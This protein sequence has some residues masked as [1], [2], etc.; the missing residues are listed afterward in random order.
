MGSDLAKIWIHG[1]SWLTIEV[2]LRN[3]VVLDYAASC[4]TT[5]ASKGGSQRH[6]ADLKLFSV[7]LWFTMISLK[8][9][10]QH[11]LSRCLQVHK[12]KTKFGSHFLSSLYHP[13]FLHFGPHPPGIGLLQ[14][15]GKWSLVIRHWS[16][17]LRAL[18]QC[19]QFCN[20]SKY[21]T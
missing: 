2:Q 15:E 10:L 19:C 3:E 6:K 16:C 17:M 4:I 9:F 5:Y 1:R 11:A 7:W 21:I 18:C 8:N 13:P 20:S 14:C 12:S